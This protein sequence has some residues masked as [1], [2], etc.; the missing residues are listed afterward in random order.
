VSR[1]PQAPTG[2]RL[3]KPLVAHARQRRRQAARTDRYGP[4]LR[5]IGEALAILRQ[6]RGLSQAALASII[7]IGRSQISKYEDA[8]ETMKL[9]TLLKMLDGLDV[10][11]QS[12]FR[13]VA[14]LAEQQGA[15]STLAPIDA[16]QLREGFGQML[17]AIDTLRDAVERCAAGDA[18]TSQL[19]DGM[20]SSSPL[21]LRKRRERPRER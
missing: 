15:G 5:H 3:D 8:R 14:A 12:Y 13:F 4:T 9:D 7:K 6:R 21:P 11:P 2:V 17:A 1:Q 10:T 18:A 19:A 16:A 20:A